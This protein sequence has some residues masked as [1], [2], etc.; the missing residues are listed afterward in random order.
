MRRAGERLAKAIKKLKSVQEITRRFLSFVDNPKW[1]EYAYE[2]AKR[3]VKSVLVD[4]AKSWRE[5]ATK[6][7]HS[8]E[9]YQLLN[10]EFRNHA[11]FQAIVHGNAELIRLLPARVSEQ[12]T[13]LAAKEAIAGR[14]GADIIQMIQ[15]Q[16]PELTD[17]QARR[18][19]RTEVAKTH[20]AITQVRSQALGLDFY[21]WQTSQD[22]R[23]RSSH[24][25]MQGVVCSFSQPPSPEAIIGV[26]STLG[27]YGPGAC[28]NCRCYAAPIIDPDLE[29]WPKKMAR[30]DKLVSLN[31]REFEALQ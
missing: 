19:A 30:N 17:W 5:A 1:T 6:G 10:E 3:M 16:V 4:N 26:K 28:P 31:K 14:R 27:H 2:E 20:S 23:V 13:R 9:I 29:T 25:H 12:I 24:R 22:Q 15:Q 8:Y 7:Q 11:Q 21:V 18:I